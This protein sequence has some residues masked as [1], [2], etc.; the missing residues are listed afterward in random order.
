[1]SIWFFLTVLFC[2][3]SSADCKT[4]VEKQIWDTLSRLVRYTLAES[5]KPTQHLVNLALAAGGFPKTQAERMTYLK[6]L[7][8][9]ARDTPEAT[10][11]FTKN[12]TKADG[13][14]VESLDEIGLDAR[15]TVRALE[16]LENLTKVSLFD[17]ASAPLATTPAAPIAPPMKPIH[18]YPTGVTDIGLLDPTALQAQLESINKMTNNQVQQTQV[19]SSNEGTISLLDLFQMNQAITT[20]EQTQMNNR[21]GVF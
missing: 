7:K 10:R 9:I 15:I 1:M 21:V 20:Y 8:Q 2:S 17:S 16:F 14:K 3:S 18:P 4:A 13:T 12:I 5:A 19:S 6:V 11:N